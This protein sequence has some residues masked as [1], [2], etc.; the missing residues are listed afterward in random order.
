[1]TTAS[2]R[3]PA[4]ES[5]FGIS[6][7]VAVERILRLSATALLVACAPQA[8]APAPTSAPARPAE[9]AKPTEAARPADAAKPTEAAGPT[10]A[11]KPAAP[12]ATT[13]PAAPTAAVPAATTAPAAAARPTEA[14]KPAAKPAETPKTGGTLRTG[15]VGDIVTVD[16]ILWQPNNSATVGMCYDALITYDDNLQPQP[17]L[18]ESWELSADGTRIKLN[19]RKGVH[20]HSGREFTSDDVQYNMLRARDPK[21][22]FAAVVAAGSAWWTGIDTSDKYTVMLTSEKPR[23]GVFDFLVYLRILDKET[24]EG[25]D[26]A[27]KVNGTG[28]FTWKEWVTGDHI[29]LERNA[30]YWDSGRP[31]L[32]GA[33]I[34]ILRDQQQMVAALEAGTLDVAFLAP[35]QDAFRLKDDPKIHRHQSPRRRSVL[36]PDG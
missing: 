11:A 5:G 34:K 24:M 29:T 14:P 28:P 20:F 6:R 25:P 12:A 22:P 7:R 9:A 26:A 10:E 30:D 16:G 13:A 23:P 3:T 21:N 35:I 27:T 31:Y 36:L 33:E 19:L 1:M 32:D 2:D 18:A 8:P 4:Q 15:M 17:R